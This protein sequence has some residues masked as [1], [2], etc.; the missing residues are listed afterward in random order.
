MIEGKHL[1]CELK[2]FKPPITLPVASTLKPSFVTCDDCPTP[3]S[4]SVNTAAVDYWRRSFE[5]VVKLLT[6]IVL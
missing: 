5:I 4:I 3:L 1:P 2:G 6:L